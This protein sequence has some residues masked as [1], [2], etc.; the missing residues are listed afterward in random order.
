[1]GYKLGSFNMYKFQAY[2]SD[3]E[4]KKDLDGIANIISSEKF[5]VIAMQEVFDSKPMD[6]IISRLGR[7]NYAG[8]WGKPNARSVQ[9]AEG[10]A[11][12]WNKRRIGLAESLTASG[13]RVYE[14]RIYQQYRVDRK[15]GQRDLVRDPF[16]GRFK[17]LNANF[18]L[19]IINAHVMFSSGGSEDETM[20]RLSDVAMRRNELDILIRSILARENT[21]RYGNNLPAYTVLLGDYNLNL[22][23]EWTNGPYLQEV[24]EITDGN[25]TYR[26]RT[27][28]DQLTT[29]KSKSKLNPDELVRGFANNYDHFTYDEDRFSDLRP[30]IRKIDTVRKYCDDDFERHR[31]E[32]SDHTPISMEINL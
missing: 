15:A 6:M 8:A 4:I 7:M 27:V 28:Q 17:P 12:I 13:K 23:R 21:M 24:V 5:D 26:M 30:K 20:A 14:P 32:I 31:K 25:Y 1:M 29:L 11:F 2:R 3:D 19:R 16:Y 22:N 18:E 9:A 10:F